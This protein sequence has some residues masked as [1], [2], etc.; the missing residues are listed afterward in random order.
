MPP[1]FKKGIKAK[2]KSRSEWNSTFN[3]TKGN[4]PLF[5]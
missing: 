5:G 3:G 1:S 2:Y 4:L